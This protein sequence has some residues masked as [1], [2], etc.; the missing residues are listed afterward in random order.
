MIF[1]ASTYLDVYESLLVID[2]D[3]DD[4][5]NKTP[6]YCL[7]NQVF[8]KHGLASIDEDCTEDDSST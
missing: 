1:T 8:G 2:D 5:N 4:P 6:H 3:D 7:L